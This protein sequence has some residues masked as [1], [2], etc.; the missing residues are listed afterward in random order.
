V[1]PLLFAVSLFDHS[2]ER[3]AEEWRYLTS[4]LQAGIFSENILCL[5][6]AVA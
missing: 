4:F 6:K 1:V 5:H 3:N 2:S